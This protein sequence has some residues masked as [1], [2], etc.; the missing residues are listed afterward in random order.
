[1]YDMNTAPRHCAVGGRFP[2][3]VELRM[4]GLSRLFRGPGSA[5]AGREDE[6]GNDSACTTWQDLFPKGRQVFYEG[7]DPDRFCAQIRSEFGFDPAEGPGWDVPAADDAGSYRSFS[8]FCPPGN[9][10]A[11]YGSGR[12]PLGS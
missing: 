6:P 2:R 10:D 3:R 9:L 5:A 4:P 8:F 1:M 11:V 7:D 12:W